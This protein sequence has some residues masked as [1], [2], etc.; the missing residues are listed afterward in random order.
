[1]FTHTGPGRTMM[2]AEVNFAR[3][4]ALTERKKQEPRI[5]HG[6]LESVRTWADARDAAEAYYL[7]VRKCK[8]GEVYNIGG[9]TV[10]TI[11][12][13]LDYLISLSPKKDEIKKVQDPELMRPYDVSLQVVDASKFINETGW[14][15]K[16]TFEKTMEDLL[17]WWRKRVGDE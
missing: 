4:I 3:Q 14:K 15:Q 13:M 5:H 17:N 16:Y 7:L 8:P 2:S 6:N 1:M 12:E 9:N 10:K 11:G